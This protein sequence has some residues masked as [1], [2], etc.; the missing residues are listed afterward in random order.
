[1]AREGDAQ[2]ISEFCFS[3]HYMMSAGVNLTDALVTLDNISVKRPKREREALSF[4]RKETQNG[5]SFAYALASD[6]YFPVFMQKAV[7]AAEQSAR[8][9]YVFEG[10]GQYYS[11]RAKSRE[12]L[13]NAL[14]Y[15]FFV[16]FAIIALII[17]SLVF[18]LPNFEL[19]F[20]DT[21]LPPITIGVMRMGEIFRKNWFMLPFFALGFALFL[22]FAKKSNNLSL[23]FGKIAL[24]LPPFASLNRAAANYQFCQAMSVT[25]KNNSFQEAL[26]FSAPVVDNAYA[27]KELLEFANKIALGE[28]GEIWFLDP[29]VTQTTIVGRQTGNIADAYERASEYSA[30]K[31][32][33][34]LERF[35]KIIEPL[36]T[37]FLGG[38]LLLIMLAIIL[39]TFQM[40]ELVY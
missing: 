14:F 1:M 20:A 32:K 18:I 11:T 34:A 22:K 17:F 3:L 39:P 6:S 23:A 25:A 19:I 12:E 31:Y 2:S 28:E 38:A 15:P 27:Q 5:G 8:L 4:L 24:I 33:K 26:I 13:I 37:L 7:Y 21:P 9:Q 16:A 29:I 35:L 40:A 30:Q 10:L 36:I